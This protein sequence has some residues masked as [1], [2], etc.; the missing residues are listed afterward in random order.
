MVNGSDMIES[1]V[2]LTLRSTDPEIRMAAIMHACAKYEIVQWIAVMVG[3]RV[4]ITPLEGQP[5]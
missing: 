5:S 1:G 3:D 4:I 2:I